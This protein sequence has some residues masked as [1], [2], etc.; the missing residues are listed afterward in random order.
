[1]HQ[2]APVER[3]ALIRGNGAPQQPASL[4]AGSAA[5]VRD[6][7]LDFVKGALVLVMVLYHWLNYFIGLDWFGYRYL[8]FLT[9]SF[10][11]ITGFVI[12]RIYLR[13]YA[14]DS[15]QL[16][17]RLVQRGA[18]LLTLFIA[19]NLLA[20][21][22]AP[23]VLAPSL[24]N[25]AAVFALGS[26]RA[27]FDILVPLAYFLMFAPFVILV[28]ARTG[29]SLTVLALGALFVTIGLSLLDASN[30]HLELVAVAFV[31]L[32]AG[33]LSDG[34]LEKTLR[35]P[36]VLVAWYVPYL[37]AIT[38]WNVLYPLQIVGVCLSVMLLYSLGD[39]W[40]GP[41]PV[42][43]CIV[44]LGRYSLLSYI[45][46]IA[47]LQLLRRGIDASAL[48][49]VTFAV[50]LVVCLALMIGAVYATHIVRERSRLAD[51][52]YRT[53]FA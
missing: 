1:M 25:A 26:G 38:V 30:P 7:T 16:R 15:P 44:D 53:V 2:V 11:L 48:A 8:R 46:Q 34:T 41:S 39:R 47:V 17:R 13:R 21:V 37:L 35:Q 27:V 6:D 43:R 31:G 3:D 4:T 52:L 20:W 10:L 32:A 12:S 42:Y 29:L 50:P 28:S 9:P 19:L 49:G 24:A 18:K 33:A 23:S 51:G 5:A 22:A 36:W 45:V 40:K 14:A